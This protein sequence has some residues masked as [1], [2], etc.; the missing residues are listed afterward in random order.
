MA[1]SV[2]RKYFQGA[3]DEI[4]NTLQKSPRGGSSLVASVFLAAVHA[5]PAFLELLP[6]SLRFVTGFAPLLLLLLFDRVQFESTAVG[7]CR[8]L[9]I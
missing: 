4:L 5:L 1:V 6:E 3:S 9:Q 8:G 7:V 2:H